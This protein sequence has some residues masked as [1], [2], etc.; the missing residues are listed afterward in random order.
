MGRHCL[1]L[2]T[3]SW[4]TRSVS[5]SDSFQLM[6]TQ[7][8]SRVDCF[9]IKYFLY[10]TCFIPFFS[11][12]FFY[13]LFFITFFPFPFFSFPFF[14]P[15]FRSWVILELFLSSNFLDKP[16]SRVL[17]P[18]QVFLSLKTKHK[19]SY[20]HIFCFIIISEIMDLFDDNWLIQLCTSI[21][22]QVHKCVNLGNEFREK[23]SE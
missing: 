12:P 15:F 13:S 8:V 20:I 23:T 17:T 14:I 7:R 16:F 5:F 11:F 3:F 1:H 18:K 10:M 9:E 21:N 4:I 22:Q 6:Q 19:D 2:C